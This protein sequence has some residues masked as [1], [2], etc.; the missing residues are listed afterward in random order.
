MTSDLEGNHRERG[1]KSNPIAPTPTL[2][3]AWLLAMVLS[4]RKPHAERAELA[5][6]DKESSA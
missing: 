6:D 4:R 5:V 1:F 3:N 2:Q